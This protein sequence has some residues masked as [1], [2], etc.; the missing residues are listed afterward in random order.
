MSSDVERIEESLN[1]YKEGQLEGKALVDYLYHKCHLRMIEV[2]KICEQ[3]LGSLYDEDL[4][5]SWA[6]S[7]K[8]KEKPISNY[9]DENGVSILYGSEED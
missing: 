4:F 9:R 5:L 3:D 8:V 6:V 7:I 2:L 1:K